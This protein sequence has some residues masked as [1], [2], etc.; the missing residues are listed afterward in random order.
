MQY[1]FIYKGMRFHICSQKMDMRKGV[2]NDI[3]NIFNAPFYQGVKN[4]KIGNG[5]KISSQGG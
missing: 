2:A 5:K 3:I 1:E 4:R